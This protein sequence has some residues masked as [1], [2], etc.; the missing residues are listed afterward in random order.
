MRRSRSSSA[1]RC[2]VPICR[3]TWST[4]ATASTTACRS[5]RHEG[6]FVK[7]QQYQKDS[8]ATARCGTWRSRRTRSRGIFMSDGRNSK[9]HHRPPVVAGDPQLRRRRPLPGSVLL[10][11]A[12]P[13]TRRATC[14]DRKPTRD[15]VCRSSSRKASAPFPARRWASSGRPPQAAGSLERGGM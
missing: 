8:L 1:T 10:I 2:T 6:Q 12:S 3:S 4:S 11:P 14:A 7:E 5:S 13:S 15:A 9:I